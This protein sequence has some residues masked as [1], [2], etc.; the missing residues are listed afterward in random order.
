[1]AGEGTQLITL[2]SAGGNDVCRVESE[3]LVRRFRETLGKVRD[4]GG[5][6][7]ALSGGLPRNLSASGLNSRLA[8]YCERN[9]WLFINN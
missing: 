7:P 4:A 2:L 8:A 6:V 1:M 3:E 9:G 5:G